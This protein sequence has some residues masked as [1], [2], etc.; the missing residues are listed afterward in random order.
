MAVAQALLFARGDLAQGVG[1][2]VV[3]VLHAAGCVQQ[4]RI[5]G[6]RQLL[7]EVF[8]MQAGEGLVNGAPLGEHHAQR[9]HAAGTGI[10]GDH[11]CLIPG[12]VND[13]GGLSTRGSCHIQD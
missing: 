1:G 12:A 6:L 8:T 7:A 10:V 13:V 2:S 4:Y 9:L 5:E 11:H 3:Q